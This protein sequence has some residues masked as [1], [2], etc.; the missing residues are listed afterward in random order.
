MKS[1]VHILPLLLN[2]VS[3]VEAKNIIHWPTKTCTE[4]TYTGE[5]G[6]IDYPGGNKDY[7]PNLNCLFKI[8]LAQDHVVQFSFSQF[9]FEEATKDCNFD[10]LKFIDGTD[11]GDPT[12]AFCSN[13]P[14][15]LNQTFSS[16]NNEIT[17]WMYSDAAT[18]GKGF[19]LDWK[20][21]KSAKP[22]LKCGCNEIGT[23]TENCESETEKCKCKPSYT[24]E[25][26]EECS[27]DYWMS[28]NE[29]QKCNACNNCPEPNKI[30]TC[31]KSNG[32]C[33]CSSAATFAFDKTFVLF[34]AFLIFLSNQY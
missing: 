1:V 9:D 16:K 11:V 28:S 27:G 23:D 21:V 7:D 26:C 29:C 18:A 32:E 2:F 3:W 5:S 6:T 8:S 22:N 4:E 12:T 30:G 13:G 10:W 33:E 31:N 34:T 20:S 15:P 17:L 14:D 25:K 19:K 24:G